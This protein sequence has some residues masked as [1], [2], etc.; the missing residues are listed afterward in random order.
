MEDK[1]SGIMKELNKFKDTALPF[2]KATYDE[3]VII[4]EKIPKL[5][6]FSHYFM[7]IVFIVFGTIISYF[8]F[9]EENKVLM[10]V[11]TFIYIL[12][13]IMILSNDN[14]TKNDIKQN[15]YLII[16]GKCINKTKIKRRLAGDGRRTN[17]YFDILTDEEKKIP[18]LSCERKV[19][20]ETE[21]GEDII[22][23]KF[24]NSYKIIKK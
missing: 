4:Q 3:E 11:V 22:M 16:T 5:K 15:N 21:I 14:K 10:F 20:E 12:F 2:R 17:Y 19:Y 9:Y 18:L 7:A 6:S 13:T 1:L 23:V 24:K 8:L